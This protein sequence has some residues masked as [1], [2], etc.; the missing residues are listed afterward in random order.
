V[1]EGG[2]MDIRLQP[3]RIP[4]GWRLDANVFYAIDPAEESV[5]L[6]YFGGSS[7]FMATLEAWR[8]IVDL[9]WRPEDDPAGE[10][11]LTVYCSPWPRTPRGRRVK[12]APVVIPDARTVHTFHS[13]DQAALV[14]ELE[15]VFETCDK[16]VEHS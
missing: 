1:V 4:A 3:L 14:R 6:G 11:Q 7:L 8:L 2:L 9:E 12:G 15:S 10:Y 16:W 5:R 13:R